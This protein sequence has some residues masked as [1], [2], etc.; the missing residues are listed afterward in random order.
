MK[1]PI[2]KAPI[3]L[4]IVIA[5]ISAFISWFTLL[6]GLAH[7]IEG[8]ARLIKGIK[9]DHPIGE[10]ILGWVI[11]LLLCFVGVFFLIVV[12]AAIQGIL[13]RLKKNRTNN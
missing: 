9:P 12:I 4:N 1:L 11:V 8:I 10:E 3:F 13:V 7:L 5:L 2:L 6:F